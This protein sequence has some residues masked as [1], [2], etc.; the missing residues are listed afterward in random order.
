MYVVISGGI[1]L[2]IS[3]CDTLTTISTTST[4][5][6]EKANYWKLLNAAMLAL[7]AVSMGI[8][9][10]LFAYFMDK[11]LIKR[12]DEIDAVPIDVE[13]EEYEKAQEE[14]KVAYKKVSEWEMLSTGK[15]VVMS[16]AFSPLQCPSSY[17]FIHGMF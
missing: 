12:K 3:S 15:R 7:S 10:F 6:E 9:M 4:E 1:Q 8:T 13:V 2:K 5:E 11:A 17:S 14:M 16:R